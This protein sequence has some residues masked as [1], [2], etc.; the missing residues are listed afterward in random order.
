M[1]VSSGAKR[2]LNVEV[3]VKELDGGRVELAVRVPPE[4]VAQVKEEVLKAFGRRADIPGF[5]KGKA[6]RSV[7]ERFI[8]QDA[9]R[10]RILE[11]LLDDA[12]DA[13]L[14]K[15]GVEALGRAEVGGAKLTGGAYDRGFFLAP[16]CVLPPL[17]PRCQPTSSEPR[18]PCT[19]R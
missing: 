3:E 4:P 16:A 15:A 18:E 5:R 9:L 7:L 13:A 10:E 11:S 6:P 2:E 19:T 14:G 1:S 8:D 17:F 12:C